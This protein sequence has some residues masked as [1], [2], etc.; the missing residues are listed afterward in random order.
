MSALGATPP[1]NLLRCRL[2]RT[3]VG[4][5]TPMDPREV[6]KLARRGEVT[7]IDVRPREE[8]HAGHIKGAINVPPAELGQYLADLPRDREIVAYCRAP[9]LAVL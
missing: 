4:L 8:F 5:V 9:L 2:E 6:V 7:V 1:F 3:L